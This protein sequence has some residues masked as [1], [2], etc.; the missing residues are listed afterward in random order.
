MPTQNPNYNGYNRSPSVSSSVGSHRAGANE[1]YTSPSDNELSKTDFE[2]KWEQ[3]IGLRNIT[4]AEELAI[5]DPL[6]TKPP[7]NSE[8]EMALHTRILST[9][10]TLITKLE[11]DELFEQTLFRGPKVGL[12]EPIISTDIDHIMRNM[13][14]PSSISIKHDPYKHAIKDSQI[15]YNPDFSFSYLA[16]SGNHGNL[17][18]SYNG[19]GTGTGMGT[20]TGVG[21]G[22]GM[23]MGIGIGTGRGTDE[24]A[25]M[26]SNLGLDSTSSPPFLGGK[27]KTKEKEKKIEDGP[28]NTNETRNEFGAGMDRV[29]TPRSTHGK[30]MLKG[31]GFV[32]R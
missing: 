24:D 17:N 28:W 8:E 18:N 26:L 2:R 31:K 15:P 6:L 21:I 11:E 1:D 14:G 23:G 13:M 27:G 10:R 20:G 9:L 19:T 25:E 3:R 4:P 30:T 32:R 22:M 12:E 16:T 7:P 29:S 5:K